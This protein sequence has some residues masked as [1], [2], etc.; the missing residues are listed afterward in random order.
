MNRLI[1]TFALVLVVTAMASSQI[2]KRCHPTAF[3][4]PMWRSSLENSFTHL[5]AQAG[6]WD[7]SP[8]YRRGQNGRNYYTRAKC[9]MKNRDACRRC[10]NYLTENS[11]RECG[12]A[13]R[14]MMSNRECMIRWDRDN[15]E[16]F[17]PSF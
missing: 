1:V 10:V 12:N 2:T 8:T 4:E 6:S 11:W 13:I 15:F 5:R 7:E 9:L 14:G 3:R 17:R 16:N